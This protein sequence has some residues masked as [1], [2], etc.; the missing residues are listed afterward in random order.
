MERVYGRY[1]D[2][3]CLELWSDLSQLGLD[4]RVELFELFGFKQVVKVIVFNANMTD[5]DQDVLAMVVDAKVATPA[6][7]VLQAKEPVASHKEVSGV[8]KQVK[9]DKVAL[10]QTLQE[11]KSILEHSKDAA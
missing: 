8:L 10:K 2:R 9:A 4:G 5:P 3:R 11:L 7:L 1:D 6:E